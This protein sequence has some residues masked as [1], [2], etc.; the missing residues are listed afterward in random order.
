MFAVRRSCVTR[1][2]EVRE[3]AMARWGMPSFQFAL[4]ESTQEAGGQT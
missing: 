2:D 3:L 4:M 1:R